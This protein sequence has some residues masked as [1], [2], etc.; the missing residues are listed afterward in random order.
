MDN[1]NSKVA[2]LKSNTISLARRLLATFPDLQLTDMDLEEISKEFRTSLFKL[3]DE[4][5]PQQ[6]TPNMPL[7]EGDIANLI[8]EFRESI[9]K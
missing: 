8:K 1:G 2:R 9:K 7:R 3:R 6:Q 4:Q 5:Q